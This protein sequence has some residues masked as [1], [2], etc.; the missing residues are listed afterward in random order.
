MSVEGNNGKKRAQEESE[1]PFESSQ[2]QDAQKEVRT[3]F[4]A[5]L[6]P[7][8]EGVEV[9][10]DPETKKLN[11]KMEDVAINAHSEGQYIRFTEMTLKDVQNMKEKVVRDFQKLREDQTKLFDD[12]IHQAVTNGNEEK[13][14]QLQKRK[15]DLLA[16]L[17]EQERGKLK[18]CDKHLERIQRKQ[19]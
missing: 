1:V 17:D 19:S 15:D 9:T 3:L 8:P 5:I 13:V 4:G 12:L 11:V 14:N 18:N 2:P 6:L 7:L 10:Q 16:H